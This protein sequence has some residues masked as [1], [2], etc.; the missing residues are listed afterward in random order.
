MREGGIVTIRR[1]PKLALPAMRLR[2]SLVSLV[3]A[4][5]IPI[6]VFGIV[7]AVLTVENEH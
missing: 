2:T 7:T 3:L 1:R 5:A 4:T 6:A